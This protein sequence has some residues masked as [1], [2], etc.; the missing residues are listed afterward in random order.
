[1]PEDRGNKDILNIS[2]QLFME[3]FKIHQITEK[4]HPVMTILTKQ[5]RSL[6]PSPCSERAV[7]SIQTTQGNQLYTQPI[8]KHS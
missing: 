4:E 7:H 6:I 2:R 5:K 1:M 3:E 8:W